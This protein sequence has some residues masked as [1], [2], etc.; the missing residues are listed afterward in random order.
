MASEGIY[1]KNI[2]NMQ[3][4]VSNINTYTDKL[5]RDMSNI[6]DT[7]NAINNNWISEETDKLS[8]VNNLVDLE[9]KFNDTIIVTLDEFIKS[10]NQLID[11]A[12]RIS[13]ND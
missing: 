1:I 3:E 11:E 8:I 12:I 13:K 5:K 10:M 6:R 7:I 9:S 2:G 4:Q